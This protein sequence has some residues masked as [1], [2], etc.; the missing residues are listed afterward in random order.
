MEN[1]RLLI[2]NIAAVSSILVILFLAIFIM[3]KGWT[4][5]SN[6]IFFSLSIILAIFESAYVV[7]VNIKD[8]F[9]SRAI[10]MIT[11]IYVLIPCLTLHWIYAITNKISNRG[12]FLRILY[13]MATAIII[14]YLISPVSYLRDSV[15]KLYFPNYFNAGSLFWI[16][17]LFFL[18]VALISLI[19]LWRSYSTANQIERNRLRYFFYTIITGYLIGSTVML[20]TYNIAIDPILGS[21]MGLYVIPLAYGI[22][23]Y[24]LLDIEIVAKRALIY[25]LS[26]GGV[27]I[28]II[29]INAINNIISAGLP[30]FPSWIIPFASG[31]VVV[32]IARLVWTQIRSLD[33]LKYEFVTVVTHKFRTPLT[34]IKWSLENLQGA[35][36]EQT[37][38]EATG[39]IDNARVRLEEL[40]DNLIGLS[41][42]EGS[43]YKYN[44]EKYNLNKILDGVIE[45]YKDQLKI[46]DIKIDFKADPFLPDIMLDK[47]KIRFAFQI[48]I[49]NS[50]NFSKKQDRIAID[51]KERLGEITV[52]ISDQGIG[53]PKEEIGNIFKKFFRGAYAKRID[54]E[55]IGVSLYMARDIIEKHGGKITVESEGINKGATFTI[56]LKL[57]T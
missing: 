7:G 51:L 40:T 17:A 22:L 2:N 55:G 1:F 8:P 15:Q 11:S 47:S 35:R 53:I 37:K 57:K 28:L 52:K 6:F 39:A 19:S 38:E 10:L 49:E 46:K 32:A 44:F 9:L 26:V 41:K 43:L 34:S 30:N 21:F 20:P 18:I 12:Y 33:N 31:I 5:K 16:S 4:R 27:G 56:K 50:I 24:E 36:D 14:M 29:I 54:T 48:L 3:S 25:T 42:S 23:R 13:G 45:R